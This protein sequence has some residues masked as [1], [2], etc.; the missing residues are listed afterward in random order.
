MDEAFGIVLLLGVGASLLLGPWILLWRSHRKRLTQR[1]EDQTRWADLTRRIHQVEQVL[2]PGA[3]AV[4][5]V[6]APDP[7]AAPVEESSPPQLKPEPVPQE[8]TPTMVETLAAAPP[9]SE[10]ATATQAA[11]ARKTSRLKSALDVEEKLGTNWLNKL[12]V[13]LL[14]LGLAFL[15]S[16]QLK[17]LGPL[18]KVLLGFALSGAM[19][20]AGVWFERKERYRILARAGVGGGWALLFF[21]TYAMYFVPAAHVIGSE[22]LDLVLLLGVAAAM[23]LHT[24]RYRSQVVTGLAFLLAFLTVGISHSDVYSLG[25]GAVLACGLVVIVGK[26][27]WFELEVFGILASYL[28]HYLWLRPIIEPMNGHRHAFAEFPASAAILGIYWAIFRVSYVWRRP[29]SQRQERASTIAALLNTILLL[30]LFKYQSTHPEWA[31]W[32]LLAIGGIETATGQLKVTR[33]RRSAVV[34][35]N[36]LGIVLLIAAFPFRYSGFGL[37]IL[38]LLEAEALLLVGVWTKEIVFRRLGTLVTL[39]VAGQLISVGAAKV[40]GIR[41][42][43]ADVS[44]QWRLALLFVVAAGVFYGNAHWLLR[45]WS[46]LFS[47]ELDRRIMHRLSFAGAVMAAIA[48]WL[49]FPEAWTAVAWCALGLAL[50]LMGKRTATSELGYQGN[51]LAL[52]AIVRALS[53]NL[54]TTASY[55][56]LSERLLTVSLV[57]VILYVSSRWS[58]GPAGIPAATSVERALLW[59]VR[60]GSYSWAASLLLGLLVW[61]ELRP[62]GVAVAWTMGGLLLLEAGLEGKSLSWRLQGYAALLAGVARIFFVNLNAAGT[63]GEISPRFYTLVPIAGAFFYSYWRLLREPE[64][65]SHGERKICIVD[66]CCWMGTLTIVSLVRFELEADWV[67]TG[68]AGLAFCLTALAWRTRQR[69]FLVQSLFLALAV[70]FRTSLHNFYERSYFPSPHWQTRWFT[71]GSAIAFLLAAQVFLF[72]LR[73]KNAPPEGSGAV[74]WLRALARRPEQVFF[75]IMLTLLTVLLAIEMRHGMVTLAWG[76]EALLV[77]MFALWVGERSFRLAGL[78]LLL[79]CAGKILLVD[80]WRLNPSDRYITL[81]VLGAALLSVSF[82]YTRYREA[83]RH[84]L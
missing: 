27:K 63:P 54:E 82:L 36:T 16:Y 29:V 77:F 55:H 1:L 69:V 38:W 50:L 72:K 39:L 14:V 76:V 49:A 41:M 52:A 12:G 61:Y 65:I 19:L 57:A 5:P 47:H 68:W 84:Y 56:G 73:E 53:I 78:G 74:K 22:L 70:L 24:L 3:V 6:P 83:I 48:A 81:I 40:Y 45:R 34:V 2:Q 80:V 11:A 35:L 7:V 32:A 23:V 37:A 66:I 28:N 79:L 9:L 59:F 17:N 64:S 21:T 25:A 33:Q 51:F 58:G 13:G 10:P 18:G 44:P 4:P 46:D 15:T 31:F 26:M 43:G 30:L 60:R 62:A 75:F 20:G 8:E 67:A 71:A 42:D